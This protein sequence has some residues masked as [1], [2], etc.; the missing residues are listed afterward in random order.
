VYFVQETNAN[1]Y[2][3]QRQSNLFGVKSLHLV[4][5]QK[6]PQSVYFMQH[7]PLIH[8]RVVFRK[9]ATKLITYTQDSSV[10]L[11]FDVGNKADKKFILGR[12]GTIF[13]LIFYL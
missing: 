5:K 6:L 12:L 7:R 9:V 11:I 8:I 4:K 10:E 1:V 13:A 2:K 3:K